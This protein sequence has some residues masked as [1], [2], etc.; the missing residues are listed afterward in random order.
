MFCARLQYEPV[1]ARPHATLL[2]NM[3]TCSRDIWLQQASFPTTASTGV[4]GKRKQWWGNDQENRPV[5][6]ILVGKWELSQFE[7]G[8]EQLSRAAERRI[9]FHNLFKTVNWSLVLNQN[10]G[11]EFPWIQTASEPVAGIEPEPHMRG[12]KRIIMLEPCNTSWLAEDGCS[13]QEHPPF[14][15]RLST[16][17]WFTHGYSLKRCSVAFV[18]PRHLR[19]LCLEAF[20]CFLI[21]ILWDKITLYWS[22]PRDICAW[23]QLKTR[24]L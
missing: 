22:H 4:W 13:L 17:D 5:K 1:K 8:E 11:C 2:P 12:P 24:Q 18:L 9:C 6:G 7:I 21:L 20:F 10:Q 16:K 15:R 14:R 19:Q 23:P 3:G